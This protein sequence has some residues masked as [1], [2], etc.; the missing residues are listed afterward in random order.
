[1]S[2]FTVLRA[3]VLTRIIFYGFAGVG[4]TIL[5]AEQVAQVSGSPSRSD[6]IESAP[7]AA[8]DMSADTLVSSAK[9][10]LSLVDAG[11]FTRLWNLSAADTKKRLPLAV[12][13]KE[14]KEA[15]A[16]VGHIS[17]RQ[18][19]GIARVRYVLSPMK[20]AVPAGLYANIEFASRQLDGGMVFELVTLRIEDDGSLK[21][22]GYVPRFKPLEF[23]TQVSDSK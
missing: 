12:F 20:D 3:S 1:M 8:Q 14:M 7:P 9:I 15:R 5:A 2:V 6:S 16:S 19:A 13:A 17:T 10:A 18:W 23:A 22:T 11:E 4:S 21:F